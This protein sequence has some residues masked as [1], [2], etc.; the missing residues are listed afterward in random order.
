M[1]QEVLGTG[2]LSNT[3]LAVIEY[4]G[5]LYMG[6]KE[7]TESFSSVHGF[8]RFDAPSGKW[9]EPSDETLRGAQDAHQFLIFNSL[10]IIVGQ[11][12]GV[13]EFPLGKTVEGDGII[14]WDGAAFSE[15]ISAADPDPFGGLITQCIEYQGLLIA[16]KGLSAGD[17]LVRKESSGQWAKLFAGDADSLGSHRSLAVYN[18]DLILGGESFIVKWN[19]SDT[20]YTSIGTLGID[21]GSIAPNVKS[22]TVF[23][24]N[25]IAAGRFDSIDGTPISNVGT[26]NPTDGWSQ[27]G[28]G[29]SDNFVRTVLVVKVLD[30]KLL[31]GGNFLDDGDGVEMKGLALWDGTKWVIADDTLFSSTVEDITFFEGKL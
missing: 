13:E 26:W 17:G 15:V 2:T 24:G 3:V 30:G 20:A 14:A 29:L 8:A 6:G 22:L 23:K 1:C 12:D 16:S 21:G 7:V 28:Q 18:D 31:A 10:L 11:F 25:L 19:I 9:L 4:K 27:M 5:L